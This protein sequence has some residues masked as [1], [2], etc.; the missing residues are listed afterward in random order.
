MEDAA[1]VK[2][3][4]RLLEYQQRASRNYYARNKAAIKA[5]STEYWERNREA[6]NQRR[7]ERYRLNHPATSSVVPVEHGGSSSDSH[8]SCHAASVCGE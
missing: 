6:I 1:K 2:R 4:L 8:S 5:K 3:A 7:R